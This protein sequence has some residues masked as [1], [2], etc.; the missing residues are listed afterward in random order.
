MKKTQGIIKS[1]FKILPNLVI[2]TEE[3]IETK[4][5]SPKFPATNL[6][7]RS[8][9]VMVNRKIIDDLLRFRSCCTDTIYVAME[10]QPR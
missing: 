1:R 7:P 8:I 5:E 3:L 9:Q 10:V 6:M 2:D 4:A